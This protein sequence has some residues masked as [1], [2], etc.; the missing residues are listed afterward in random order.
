VKHGLRS[1]VRWFDAW[2]G[3]E[4]PGAPREID[5]LR[6]SPFL[7][8]HA[9]VLLVP[10]VGWSP[11]ALWV[12]AAAY[13]VRMF[14]VT[15]FY[16][17]FLSHRSFKTSRALQLVLALLG[18]SA[19]QRGPLWW[20]AHHRRHHRHADGELDAHSP[21]R[22][23]FWWS[24][25]GWLLARDNFRTR[26]EEVRDLMRYPELRFLDRFDSL[27]PL[28]LVPLAYGLGAWLAR[29][30]PSLGTDGPQMLVWGFG[31]STVL[32]HHGTFAINSFAH[33]AGTRRFETHDDSRNNWL[34]ALVTLGE[35]WHN[36]HHAHP[37]AARQGLRWWEL[38]VTW[39]VLRLLAALGLVWDLRPPLRARTRAAPST[40]RLRRERAP[41]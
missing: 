16:H 29:A 3:E 31:V 25:V 36:N 20:A 22:D 35:G 23:G 1:V 5:W 11:V 41:R 17:R 32:L 10:L 4:R 13:V 19:V 12:A 37:G 30:H 24:H 40:V 27:V 18:A 38:D 34:L 28:L 26:R 15:A 14:A 2:A 39:Y 7:V 9:S 21:A 33:R 8:L 6:V